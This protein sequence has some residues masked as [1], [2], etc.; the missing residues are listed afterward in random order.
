MRAS[1]WTSSGLITD[2]D[3]SDV[4]ALC[5][6]GQNFF[7]WAPSSSVGEL[8]FEVPSTGTITIDFGNCW[9]GTG[10]V[11]L[12]HNVDAVA[13]AQPSTNSVILELSV[14]IG[15]VITLRD[16]GA[17]SVIRLNSIIVECPDTGVAALSHHD[18]FGIHKDPQLYVPFATTG[19]GVA[20]Q[21]SLVGSASVGANGLT[22]DGEDDI[23]T[24]ATWNYAI[25][26]TWTVGIWFY[27][28]DCKNTGVSWEYIYSHAR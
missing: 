23:A 9:Y 3:Q 28:S 10:S 26:G 5:Q 6:S 17:D 14:Q 18:S 4:A 11:V 7:A 12:K 22:L 8:R 27:K 21:A 25:D 24:I 2:M 20:G 19:G 16:E 15:D 1:G 13:T